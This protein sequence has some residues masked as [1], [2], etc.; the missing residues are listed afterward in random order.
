M[1]QEEF[2]LV[3][4]L[5]TKFMDSSC[6][7]FWKWVLWLE[8]GVFNIVKSDNVTFSDTLRAAMARKLTDNCLFM[9]IVLVFCF[10]NFTSQ[11]GFHDISE[12]SREP[13]RLASNLTKRNLK[14]QDEKIFKQQISFSP[15]DQ[16]M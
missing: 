4:I 2:C 12:T 11:M 14:W 3:F 13:L 16:R 6:L 15:S 10:R 5:T 7:N 1:L 8:M 9:Q